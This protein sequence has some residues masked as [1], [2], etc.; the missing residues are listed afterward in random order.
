MGVIID[1]CE[2]VGNGGGAGLGIGA[3]A[4]VVMASF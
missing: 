2:E 4:T 1:E 3:G